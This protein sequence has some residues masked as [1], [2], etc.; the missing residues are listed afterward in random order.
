MFE[1]LN[2]S[3]QEFMITPLVIKKTKTEDKKAKTVADIFSG[4]DAPIGAE[5]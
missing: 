4:F 1:A 3:P 2:L 5:E